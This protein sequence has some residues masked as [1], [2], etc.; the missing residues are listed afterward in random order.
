MKTFS[1]FVAVAALAG[2]AL[3][4]LGASAQGQPAA[5]PA[6]APQPMVLVV[7]I[8][9]VLRES[10]VG[11][12]IGQQIEQQKS[13]Y[14]KDIAAQEKDLNNAGAELKRQEQILARDAFEARARELQQRAN[15]LQKN[16]EGKRETLQRADGGATNQVL[17][18]VFSIIRDIATE[19]RATHVLVRSPQ[20][21][22]YVDPSFDVTDETLR[23]LDQRLPA[24]AVSFSQPAGGASTAAT[25]AGPAQAASKGKAKADQ[26][27]N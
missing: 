25:P 20:I 2:A 5:A 4:P 24:L 7:D 1:R 23:R 18:T 9:L 6:A 14:Q 8:P 27:K 17:Q 12:G 10:K 19:R 13:V 21:V 26:K 15:E 3:T 22:A 16:F 11:K